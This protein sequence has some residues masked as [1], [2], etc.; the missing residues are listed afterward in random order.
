[1][2]DVIFVIHN[3]MTMMSGTHMQVLHTTQVSHHTQ[4]DLLTYHVC[5][6]KHMPSID[7]A[8]LPRL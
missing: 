5:F 4:I 1:M 6:V 2:F 3:N 8:S 7:R